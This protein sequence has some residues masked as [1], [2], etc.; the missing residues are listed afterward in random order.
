MIVPRAFRKRQ[1][2][3]LISVP[4]PG[5]FQCYH[6]HS[7]EAIAVEFT[8]FLRVGALHTDLPSAVAENTLPSEEAPAN[9]EKVPK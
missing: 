4:C 2:L 1:W 3:F 9:Q 7:E 6:D 8:P 5:M